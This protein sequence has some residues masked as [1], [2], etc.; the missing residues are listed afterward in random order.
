MSEDS[1]H[2][3]GL[4]RGTIALYIYA[5]AVVV[6]GFLITASSK[7]MQS[8]RLG[9]T[10]VHAMYT[11][12]TISDVP[13]QYKTIYPL[14]D[15]ESWESIDIDHPLRYAVAYHRFQGSWCT[16]SIRKEFPGRVLYT[17]NTAYISP[18]VYWLLSYSVSKQVTNLM[19]YEVTNLYHFVSEEV[20]ME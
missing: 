20:L 4:R 5:I 12:E 15:Q 19:E 9:S 3:A 8:I 6:V 7:S 18:E 13:T 17:L 11:F 2:F 14:L 10:I 1:K 16:A